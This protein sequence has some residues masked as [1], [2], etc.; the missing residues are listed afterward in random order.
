MTSIDL[1]SGLAPV[2]PGAFSCESM[3]PEISM[4]KVDIFKALGISR[5]QLYLLLEEEAL[6]TLAMALR[7]GRIFRNGP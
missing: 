7:Q 2:Y 1:T 6:V 3:L 5:A 4:S